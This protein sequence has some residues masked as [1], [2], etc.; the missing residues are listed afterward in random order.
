[1]AGAG[2]ALQKLQEFFERKAALLEDIRERA[3]RNFGVHRNYGFPDLVAGSFFNRNMAALL[4]SCK[5]P[6]RFKALT[7]RSP[8]TL[9]SL[10]MSTGNFDS[11]PELRSLRGPAV[12]GAPSFEIELDSLAQVGAGGLNVFSL[13]RDAQLGAACHIPIVFF[14]DEGREAI[15]HIA[16]LAKAAV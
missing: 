11:S 12:G 15:V 5:K 14:G 7:T 3:L 9:G 8:E 4:R 6:A 2:A 10:G 1:M 13:R 16:M